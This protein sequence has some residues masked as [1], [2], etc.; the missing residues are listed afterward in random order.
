MVYRGHT[1]HIASN[2]SVIDIF[3][4]LYENLAAEDEVVVSKGWVAAT[5]YYFLAKKGIL[6]ISDLENFKR[7]I[8][9]STI[10]TPTT[11]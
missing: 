11:S 5:M 8:M 2:F 9:V 3:T 10:S 4:V 1:S 6:S 7:F